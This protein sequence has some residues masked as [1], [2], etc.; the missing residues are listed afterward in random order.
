[1]ASLLLEATLSKVLLAGH[2]LDTK[3]ATCCQVSRECVAAPRAVQGQGQALLGFQSAS[4]LWCHIHCV[5]MPVMLERLGRA[6][7]TGQAM[8]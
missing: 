3:L 1:M 4:L 5:S 2:L 7:Y 6:V 8:S